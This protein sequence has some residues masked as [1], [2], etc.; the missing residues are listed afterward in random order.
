MTT[1]ARNRLRSGSTLDQRLWPRRNS[2]GFRRANDNIVTR[3]VQISACAWP[4]N[5]SREQQYAVLYAFASA[6]LSYYIRAA[7]KSPRSY[8]AWNPAA[9][10]CFL[11]AKPLFDVDKTQTS[12]ARTMAT[13]PDLANR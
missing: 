10:C 5:R 8:G 1:S 4:W 12:V 11:S 2:T 6:S 13:A 9:C 3:V 7:T